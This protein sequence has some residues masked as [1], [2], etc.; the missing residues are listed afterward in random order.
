MSDLAQTFAAILASLA[1]LFYSVIPSVYLIP[2][3]AAP[4]AAHA[5]VLFGGDM[6]FDRSIRTTVEKKGWDYVF[7]CI[8]PFLKNE[9]LVVANLE[10]PLTEK[11]SVSVGTVPGS[12]KNMI[13]TFPTSTARLLFTHN[14]RL[15]NLGNNHIKDF[16]EDGVL[17]TISALSDARVGYFGDPL[18]DTVDE[19]EVGGVPF[20]FINYNEFSAGGKASTTIRQIQEARRKGRLPIVYTH[21][22]VEYASTTPEY[23]RVLAHRF[24]DSGAEVIIGS[25]PHVVGEREFYKEKYIYY[26]LG[27]LIFDQ[28]WYE[29]VRHGLM[30][31]VV[32]DAQ[33]VQYVEEVR[34]EL[35]R[36][37]RTCQ[38]E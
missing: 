25:H 6:M 32:F 19:R 38:V 10:G 28:Y 12:T 5:V 3:I 14:I 4:N 2:E 21:W 17:S 1:A 37:G 16:G 22:G 24:V 35:M 15:V 33:G 13:F 23:L 18:G 26:S 20:S 36:D 7:S 34:V 8:D 31:R 27:N 29:A 9:D 30:V 11:P